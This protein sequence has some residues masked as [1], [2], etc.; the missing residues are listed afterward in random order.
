MD[1]IRLIQLR[2]SFYIGVAVK[3]CVCWI[4][5]IVSNEKGT[6]LQH[7]RTDCVVTFTGRV[8]FRIYFAL[9]VN[10]AHIYLY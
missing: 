5:S 2:F 4:L 7:F 9:Q 1:L 3:N 8:F 10:N 6:T